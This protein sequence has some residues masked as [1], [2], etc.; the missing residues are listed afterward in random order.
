LLQS[1]W[2]AALLQPTAMLR[3]ERG[4]ALDQTCEL[5]GSGSHRAHRTLEQVIA[6]IRWRAKRRRGPISGESAECLHSIV[7]NDVNVGRLDLDHGIGE[8]RFRSRDLAHS[9]HGGRSAR[10]E[11]RPNP[12]CQLRKASLVFRIVTGSGRTLE[13]VGGL[14]EEVHGAVRRP[15]HHLPNNVRWHAGHAHHLGGGVGDTEGPTGKNCRHRPHCHIG[16]CTEE[17]CGRASGRAAVSER[18][19]SSRPI[20]TSDHVPESGDACALGEP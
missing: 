6:G 19:D 5:L 10:R 11:V 9:E 12:M 8:S 7:R 17:S 13:S 15:G 14:H 3:A 4:Y 18:T 20:G 1:N 16:A 2:P